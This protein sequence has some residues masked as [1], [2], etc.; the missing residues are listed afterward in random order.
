MA[1][2]DK[3]PYTNFQELN[4]DWLTQE[5]S[6]VRDNR[7][8]SDASAAAAL[9][10]EQ[11]AAASAQA[12]AESAAASA[13]S[14][15][16][17]AGS[18]SEAAASKDASAEYLEQIGTHT[19]GAVADWLKENLTPTTPPVDSTLSI[20]GAAADAQVAGNKIT[21]LKNA[22]EDSENFL[23]TQ[24]IL[25]IPAKIVG[26]ISDYTINDRG[27]FSFSTDYDLII[28][29][30]NSAEKIILN[31]SISLY[32]YYNTYPAV[33]AV[34][35]ASTMDSARHT[36]SV[37]EIS[38]IS[39]ATYVCIRVTADDNTLTISTDISKSLYAT[40]QSLLADLGDVGTL[41]EKIVNLYDYQTR[42]DGAFVSDTGSEQTNASYYHSDYIAVLPNTDYML[43]TTASICAI[44]Y[45]QDKA[46]LAKIK[47][48]SWAQNYD[49]WTHIKTTAAQY[50]IKVNG[51]YTVA[52]PNRM[53]VIT[54]ITPPDYYVPYDYSGEARQSKIADKNNPLKYKTLMTI[55]DSITDGVLADIDED[56]G[57]HKTYGGLVALD[58]DM[59]F[60]NRGWSGATLMDCE[61]F[62]S[63]KPFTRNG[64]IYPNFGS[65]NKGLTPC[66]PD[67][68]TIWF[69]WNDYAKAQT[70]EGQPGAP[71]LGTIDDAVDTTYY[72]AW[73]VAL[74]ALITTYPNA[75]I[76]VIIPYGMN[77]DW[78]NAV[79]LEAKKWG[80]PYLDMTGEQAPIIYD[81]DTGIVSTIAALR[82][83]TYL[84]DGTHPNQAG[85]DY[86]ASYYQEFLRRL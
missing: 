29:Q 15:T 73:N 39:G 13:E 70:Y 79:R 36:G 18:A 66:E 24:G 56:T 33:P 2:Y 65:D 81:S 41:A 30:L 43:R 47:R 7:D 23:N 19:A 25:M 83:S 8:A 69:G 31:Q 71:S 67:Y 85:Y 14:A 74:N 27:E 57:W 63:N 20:A 26:R 68:I 76:G 52:A 51:L 72:G 49:G 35:T 80:L 55:G 45:S 11:A 82:K 5:V 78:R 1:F 77:A 34:G 44:G 12:S 64:V 21:D 6:K 32:G 22:I 60:V 62:G 84:A 42:T 58:N 75:K 48:E 9:A 37:T 4:L 17:A 38:A 54:G 53:M 50:W 3:F 16:E 59:N 46:T 86:I 10:S 40:V 61:G 28:V